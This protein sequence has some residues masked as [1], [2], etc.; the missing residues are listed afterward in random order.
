M[1]AQEEEIRAAEDEGVKIEYLTAPLRFQSDNGRVQKLICQRMTLGEFDASGRRRPTP[2]IGSEYALDVDQAIIAVGQEVV[3]CFDAEKAN[4][5]VTKTG[6]IDIIKGKKAH[7]SAP[8]VFAG[9]DV[10]SG[11]DTVVAA[12]AAGHLAAQEIDNAIRASNNE[13]PYLP[14]PEET[15]EIP[16]SIE[17]DIQEMARTPSPEADT[18]KRIQSFCE[19][20][21]GFARGDALREASRCLRC[22]IKAE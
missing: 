14:P 9:G 15:I 21:L 11:P 3:S 19:V 6:L 1:P 10:V 22:D 7:T 18:Y 13:P 17:E 20:E 4:I 5:Q 2:L 12:I 16:M 8:M